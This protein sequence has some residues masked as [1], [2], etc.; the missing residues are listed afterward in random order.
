MDLQNR[1]RAGEGPLFEVGVR[2]VVIETTWADALFTW[3]D[4]D[5]HATAAIP[6]SSL[7]RYIVQGCVV[8]GS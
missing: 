3:S 8:L 7:S 4:A 1:I 5:R 6:L 2:A